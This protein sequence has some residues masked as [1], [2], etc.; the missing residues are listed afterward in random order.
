MLEDNTM[1]PL[2]KQLYVTIAL[3]KKLCVEERVDNARMK[4]TCANK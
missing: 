1:T 3:S 4:D 2:P